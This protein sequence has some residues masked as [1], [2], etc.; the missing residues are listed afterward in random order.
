MR[1]SRFAGNRASAY[2]EGCKNPLSHERADGLARRFRVWRKK[3]GHRSSGSRL[4]S[5]LGEAV[6]SAALVMVGSTALLAWV[7]FRVLTPAAERTAGGGWGSWLTIGVSA[8]IAVLGLAGLVLG[9]M[10]VGT[11]AERR[12][13]MVE[14]AHAVELVGNGAPWHRHYPSIPRADILTDSPGIALAYRLPIMRSPVWR[15]LALGLFCLVWNGLVSALIKVAYASYLAGQFNGFLTL[16]IVPFGLV[17]LRS[18]AAFVQQ[19]LIATGVGPCSLEVSDHPLYPG[20]R[21]E[22]F[23]TQSGRLRLQSFQVWFICEEEATYLQ[24]TDIRTERRVVHEQLILQ[25][26]H[27]SIE[28]GM[29]FHCRSEMVIPPHSMHSFHSQHNGIEWKLVVR[30]DVDRW[31]S[32]E[33]IYPVILLPS[34]SA[35]TGEDRP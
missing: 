19:A 16:F 1:P 3:R 20:Q 23:V 25:R 28:P 5:S 9:I 35:A 33:R 29:P 15:L 10:R 21:Y 2:F 4:A 17:G 8:S 13:A 12:S 7:I 32:Y 18:M 27:F 6:F 11:S 26:D 34:L 24:G 31:P 30:A 14:R 22:V